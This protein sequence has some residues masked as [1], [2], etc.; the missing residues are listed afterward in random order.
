MK[1]AL[2][3][4]ATAVGLAT[5]AP[6]GRIVEHAIRL[7][8]MLGDLPPVD[9]PQRVAGYFR[10]NRTEDAQMFYFLFRSRNDQESDPVVLWMTGEDGGAVFERPRLPTSYPRHHL[11]Q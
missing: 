3:L 1:L 5:A 10:L 8:N 9:P 7:P 11:T 6:S 4:V 2:L